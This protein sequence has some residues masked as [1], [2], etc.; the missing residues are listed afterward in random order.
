MMDTAVWFAQFYQMIPLFARIAIW[1]LYA[2]LA[3]ISGKD[4]E[5]DNLNVIAALLLNNLGI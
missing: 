3:K 2:E 1:L 5:M 4:K